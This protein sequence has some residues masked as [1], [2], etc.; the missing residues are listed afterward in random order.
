[1]SFVLRKDGIEVLRTGGWVPQAYAQRTGTSYPATV[2]QDYVWEQDG[3]SL[4]WE[5]DPVVVPTAEQVTA[6]LT[7]SV[8]EWL[9]GEARRKGYDNI[10]SACSYA[11]APNPFQAESQAYTA[12]RGNVWA[13]CYVIMGDVQAGRRGIPS[14]TELIAELPACPV[15]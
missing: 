8:Q 11:G 12:W 9:D 6:N 14:A 15:A 1:M 5:Q 13:A 4:A 7:A 2:G 10:V 3:Y